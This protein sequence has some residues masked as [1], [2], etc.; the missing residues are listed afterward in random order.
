MSRMED[1]W[2]NELKSY[3]AHRRRW[4]GG[5]GIHCEGFKCLSDAASESEDKAHEVREEV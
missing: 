4:T 5:S 2:K 3:R 1:G